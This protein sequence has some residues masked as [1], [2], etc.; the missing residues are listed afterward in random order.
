MTQEIVQEPH[1]RKAA[2]Y[3]AISTAQRFIIK[4]PYE[5]PGLGEKVSSAAVF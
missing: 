2:V 4:V 5:L 3:A 1:A